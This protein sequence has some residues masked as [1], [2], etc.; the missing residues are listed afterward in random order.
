[1]HDEIHLKY[2]KNVSWM[3]I[4]AYHSNFMFDDF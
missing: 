1:M 3:K 2:E 4:L